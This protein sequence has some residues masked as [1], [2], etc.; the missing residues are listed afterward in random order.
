MREASAKYR[1]QPHADCHHGQHRG[2]RE[3]VVLESRGRIDEHYAVDG[4]CRGGDRA[5]ERE[6]S[7]DDG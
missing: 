5:D 2:T 7:R 6:N 4:E 3:T 1:Y